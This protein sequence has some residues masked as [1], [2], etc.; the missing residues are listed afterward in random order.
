MVRKKGDHASAL[1]D[2]ALE[3]FDSVC[4]GEGEGP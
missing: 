4:I 1:P 2:E 3:H